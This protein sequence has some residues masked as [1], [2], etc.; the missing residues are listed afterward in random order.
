MTI[1]H[2]PDSVG[3]SLSVRHDL[4]KPEEP[5]CQ[6]DFAGINTVVGGLFDRCRER[7]GL[8][9]RC[10]S[11]AKLP[12]RLLQ[13]VAGCGNDGAGRRGFQVIEQSP[14]GGVVLPL[15]EQHGILADGGVQGG[16]HQPGRTI[17]QLAAFADL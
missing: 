8:S 1:G 9:G 16:G 6:N 4:C 14:G 13:A 10:P 5:A 3:W 11:S 12:G 15:A 2:L 7:V 17:L